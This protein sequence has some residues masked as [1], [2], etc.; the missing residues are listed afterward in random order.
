MK[1]MILKKMIFFCQTAFTYTKENGF[2]MVHADDF[3]KKM[4][5]AKNT[6]GREI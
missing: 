3:T 4:H 2:E 5:K 1:K 6:I